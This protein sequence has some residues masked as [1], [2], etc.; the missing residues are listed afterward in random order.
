MNDLITRAL[1]GLLYSLIIIITLFTPKE[2]FFGVFF[3]LGCLT[4][5]EFLKL[6]K[7]KS[8]LPYILLAGLFIFFNYFSIKPFGLT[9]FLLPSLVINLVLVF[10]LFSAKN[11]FLNKDSQKKRLKRRYACIIFYLISGFVFLTQIAFVTAAY[12]PQ[13]LIGIFILV[14]ANDTFAYL[15]GKNFGKNKLMPGISPKK[16]IEGL[17]GGIIGAIVTGVNKFTFIKIYPVS[18]WI[19][20]SVIVSVFGTIG[21]LVQSK[22]KRQAGVKDSGTIMP[23]HGGLYDRLDS[24]LFASPFIYLFLEIIHYVS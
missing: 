6:L 22:F 18:I 23:G 16:T 24:I 2:W 10:D 11:F 7:I 19:V 21:D 9:L 20:L 1:S 8:F 14:W 4:I 3:I 13:I 12:T 17:I 15:L 5:F